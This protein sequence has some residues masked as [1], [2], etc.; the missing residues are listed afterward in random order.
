[1]LRIL[2]IF[3]LILLG[4]TT[5]AYNSILEKKIKKELN[6]VFDGC[7]LTNCSLLETHTD[8]GQIT[9]EIFLIKDDTAEPLGYFAISQGEGRFEHF[10]FMV[11][12]NR[13]KQIQ[14]VKILLYKSAYGYE[15]GSKHWL[16]QFNDKDVQSNFK[17]NEDIQAISGAT[18]S[19]RGLIKGVNRINRILANVP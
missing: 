14:K 9:T 4:E 6:D 12:Y 15:I 17:Y 16:K 3:G 11:I 1:M 7:E 5:F 8:S 18:V 10:D 19:A 2:I 13:L